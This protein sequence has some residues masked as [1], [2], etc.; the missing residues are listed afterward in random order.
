MWKMGCFPIFILPTT[1]R[2]R[3][4]LIIQGHK[5]LVG[6]ALPPTRRHSPC[7]F[8]R[9]ALPRPKTPFFRSFQ[10]FPKV[11]LRLGHQA[12]R[13]GYTSLFFELW[14][15]AVFA[16]RQARSLDSP[17]CFFHR[18]DQQRLL[19]TNH[20]FGVLLVCTVVATV[21]GSALSDIRQ[22]SSPGD[23]PDFW[24]LTDDEITKARSGDEGRA[25]TGISRYTQHNS[26]TPLIDAQS[27][28]FVALAAC[29]ECV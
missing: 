3:G 17:F 28:W 20:L 22:A 27:F 21:A 19:M 4:S 11:R 23:G 24:M 10:I 8:A 26:L 16:N 29:Y 15:F 13:S 18:R 12:F 2:N 5:D 9:C 6:Y 25:A 14:L 1:L 7:S